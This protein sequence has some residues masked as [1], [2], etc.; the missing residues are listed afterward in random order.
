MTEKLLVL[1]NITKNFGAIDLAKDN[2]RTAHCGNRVHHSPTIAM[3]LRQCMQIYIAV[4]HSHVPT[5]RCGV[6]PN[7]SMS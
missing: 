3:K 6:Q 5:K 2:M 4:I 7:I 1:D